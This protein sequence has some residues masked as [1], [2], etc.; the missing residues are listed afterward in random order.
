MNNMAQYRCKDVFP[1]AGHQLDD[2][3]HLHNLASDQ[4][5]DAHRYVPREQAEGTDQDSGEQG[6]GDASPSQDRI[7]G[8]SAGPFFTLPNDNPDHRK[9]SR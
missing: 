4:K 8:L 3:L 2:V 5:R 1:E 9:G 6:L 7:Q